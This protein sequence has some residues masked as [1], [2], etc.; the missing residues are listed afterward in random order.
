MLQAGN[1]TP[2]RNLDGMHLWPGPTGP[3]KPVQVHVKLDPGPFRTAFPKWGMSES[4][5]RANWQLTINQPLIAMQGC[6]ALA[7]VKI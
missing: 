7:T 4:N 2:Q 1:T 3:C 5:C 6:V